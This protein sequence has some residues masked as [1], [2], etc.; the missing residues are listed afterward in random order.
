[1]DGDSTKA[2]IDR[3][4]RVL[5]MAFADNRIGP[6][7]AIEAMSKMTVYIM[8]V[9]PQTKTDADFLLRDVFDAMGK[10]PDHSDS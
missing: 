6:W 4:F 8:K 7:I 1:M 5:Q 2:E 9:C 3:A 10:S